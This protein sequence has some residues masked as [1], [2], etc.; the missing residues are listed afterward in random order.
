MKWRRLAALLGKEFMFGSKSFMFIFAVVMPVVVSLFISLLAGTLFAGKPRLGLAD[1]GSSS[2]PGRLSEL[3]Y[4]VSRAYDTPEQ[5][6]GEVERGALD[7]GIVLPAGFDAA[8]Q[9][10]ETTDLE[11]YL[12]GE[13]LLK[14]RTQLGVTLV[15]EMVALAGRQI[16]VE[17][18]TILLG[19]KANIPWDV[20]LFPLVVIMAIALGG[21]M[22]PATSLVD[23]KQKRT[24]Q[25]LTTTPASLGEVLLAK[26]A[27]GA[28]ISLVMGSV[29]LA[30]NSAFGAHAGLLLLILGLSAVFAATLGVIMGLWMK[31][32]TTLFTAFK[33]IGILL[34]AP[35]FI[36]LFPQLPQWVARIFPTYYMI[37]PIVNMSVHSATWPDV[38]GDV[39]ILC[40]LIVL[41]I[42]A[43]ALVVRRRGVLAEGRA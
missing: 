34:Y 30:I 7:M 42:G 14:H 27:A 40:A 29:I 24:L 1:L 33:S 26:G 9:R 12:W 35:A 8:L 21:M 36:Y 16:P 23:E 38:A 6:R 32:I 13:S 31:D 43:A 37:G 20:R 11:L 18:A 19:D 5:L 22:V 28:L 17:T 3:S 15:R 41:A 10:G 25:A 4:L 39:Y 2:L